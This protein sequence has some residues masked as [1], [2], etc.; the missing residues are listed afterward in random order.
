MDILVLVSKTPDTKLN[1]SISDTNKDI[2]RESIEYVI[3]PYDEHAIEAA[4]TLQ[5]QHGGTITYLTV[6]PKQDDAI[7]RKALARGGDK[8]IRIDIPE[9][10][11]Y[12]TPS[13]KAKIIYEV[14]KDLKYDI[15]L[16]GKESAV[17]EAGV[18]PS[19]LA[20]K[21]NIPIAYSVFKMELKDSTLILSSHMDEGDMMLEVSLPAMVVVDRDLNTPKMPS[22]IG[23]MKAK[24]KPIEVK[25]V[26]VELL[27]LDVDKMTLPETSRKQNKLTPE[28]PG[29]AADH[30]IEFL[31]N[32]A[33]IL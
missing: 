22:A 25:S 9:D 15:I 26:D 23:I 8:A 21:L 10:P 7:L 27:R 4:L 18:I 11:D 5:K 29:Q 1:L 13:T 3:S 17:D 2:D 30:I 19:I 16:A 6:G 14:L 32:E 12:L 28:T 20:A 33:R 31:K 24:R